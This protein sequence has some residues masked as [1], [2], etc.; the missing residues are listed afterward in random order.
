MSEA[1]DTIKSVAKAGLA[2][3]SK[4]PTANADRVW[5]ILRRDE[6]G[7]LNIGELTFGKGDLIED[8]GRRWGGYTVNTYV[9]ICALVGEKA[10]IL[11]EE[12]YFCWK[13]YRIA[14]TVG[15]GLHFSGKNRRKR[16]SEAR[17]AEC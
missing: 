6:D 3:P 16:R 1:L 11:L 14:L 12:F 10:T 4:R 13:W 15:D 7:S 2:V 5:L 8:Q 17:L 9:L